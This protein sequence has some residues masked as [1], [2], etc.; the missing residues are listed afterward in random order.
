MS[1]KSGKGARQRRKVRLRQARKAAKRQRY[2]EAAKSR[3]GVST[4][5]RRKNVPYHA[6][7]GHQRSAKVLVHPRRAARRARAYA[8]GAPRPKETKDG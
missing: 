7:W 1:H 2:L 5:V 8:R 6:R 3:K 4:P